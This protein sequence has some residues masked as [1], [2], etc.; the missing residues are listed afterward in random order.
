MKPMTGHPQLEHGHT[1]IAN[2]LLEALIRYP[3]NGG[4]YKILLAIIRLTYG[5][6]RTERPIK[7]TDLAQAT[8]LH[9]RYVHDVLMTLRQQG[10]LF[11]DRSARPHTYRLNKAYFG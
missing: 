7:Q 3:F 11:R 9:L 1:R 5:W 4:E 8:G 10:V 2:E 6:Q